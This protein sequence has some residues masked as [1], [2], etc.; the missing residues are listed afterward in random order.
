M[1]LV[2]GLGL[3]HSCSSPRKDL[4]SE[5]LSLTWPRIFFV[6][7]A[8]VSSLMSLTPLLIDR[9]L[10][11]HKLFFTNVGNYRNILVQTLQRFAHFWPVKFWPRNRAPPNLI[12]K[13]RSSALTLCLNF[14]LIA[15]QVVWNYKRIINFSSQKL[16]F[17]YVFCVS[18][19]DHVT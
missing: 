6:S 8:L 1:S 17:F 3:E 16:P 10:K 14:S 13:E 5:G 19:H 18:I 11:N 12:C 15:R 7:L 4:S 2:L 9:V